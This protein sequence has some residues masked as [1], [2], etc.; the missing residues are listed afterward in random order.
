MNYPVLFFS[1][2]LS[3]SA[4]CADLN[5]KAFSHLKKGEYKQARALFG[6][7]PKN[8]L[9]S[10]CPEEESKGF[11]ILSA[12]AHGLVG[13]SAALRAKLSEK[14]FILE[15]LK[16]GPQYQRLLEAAQ[17]V[18][19]YAD[20]ANLLKLFPIWHPYSNVGEDWQVS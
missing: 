18:K 16:Q 8:D 12:I 17:P 13:D 6:L 1:L 11:E 4:R 9:F 3:F 20:A 14:D 2:F 5:A 19:T 15:A 10:Q 7:A